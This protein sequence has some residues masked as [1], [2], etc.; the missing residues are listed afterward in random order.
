MKVRTQFVCSSCGY[1]SPQW[2]GKCPNCGEWNTLKEITVSGSKQRQRQEN[3]PSV[4]SE[5]KRLSTVSET[6]LQRIDTGIEEF[7]RV[8]GGGIVPGSATLLSGDPGIGKSTLLLTVLAAIGGVYVAGEESAEQVKLRASRL[9]ISGDNIT[10]VSETRLEDILRYI[11]DEAQQKSKPRIIIIDSIQTIASDAVEGGAGS[12]SQVRYCA[13]RLV[14]YAKAYTVA[15][16]LIGHVTKEGAIAGPR[17][18]EHMVDC[19]LYFEGERFASARILRTLK[20][21]FGAVE[22]VG[23]FEM[24]DK[25]LKEVRNPSQLFLSDR[26]KGVPG[27][28]VTVL[29]EG[30]RP[31]LVEIQALTVATQFPMPR[32][33][34]SGTDSNRV[35]LLTAIIQKRLSLLLGNVDIFVNVSGG[36]KVAEPAIDLAIVAAIISSFSNI[37]LKPEMAI[38][39]EVGLLGEVRTV[40]HTNRRVKEAQRLGF[41]II[42]TP[43]N[44]HAIGELHRQFFTR[45]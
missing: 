32:R 44:I 7:D 23:V 19:V 5:P 1:D 2:L 34:V 14:T 6:A 17:L 8:V 42:A 39:G 28:V 18:L 38:F 22:E 35:Q 12:V 20:N 25:G 29:L 41:T 21:R 45:K 30:T 16:L 11:E 26:V 43:E 40:S 9:G 13:E 10:M 36:I 3:K 27:S 31:M 37:A 4:A 24:Q 15:I 33:V